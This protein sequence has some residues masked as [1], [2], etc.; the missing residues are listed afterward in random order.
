MK[1]ASAMNVLTFHQNRQWF[2]GI[3]ELLNP[4]LQQFPDPTQTS[5]PLILP[6]FHNASSPWRP[7]LTPT[8]LIRGARHFNWTTANHSTLRTTL[9]S[10]YSPGKE[11][12]LLESRVPGHSASDKPW[13][14][15]QNTQLP[16]CWSYPNPWS[17][18]CPS[19]HFPCPLTYFPYG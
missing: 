6:P 15:L 7:H 8:G 14:L 16:R 4:G 10:F 9:S 12:T 13:I 1:S 11:C 17:L 2:C 5:N 19:R 3:N 18:N